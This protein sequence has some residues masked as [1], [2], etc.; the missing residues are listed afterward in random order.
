[1]SASSEPSAATAAPTRTIG[2]KPGCPAEETAS[3]SG[4]VAD[5]SVVLPS[6]ASTVT[7]TAA[8]TSSVRPSEMRM[9]RGIVRAGSSTSSPRVAMRA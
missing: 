6:S 8:Y 3:A 5:A 9:A 4:A 2:T 1:M 7:A